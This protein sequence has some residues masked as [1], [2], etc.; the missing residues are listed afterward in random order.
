MK[1]VAR[2][3]AWLL[4]LSIP[5]SLPQ[6]Q[7]G[8]WVGLCAPVAEAPSV[9]KTTVSSS[10]Y[11]NPNRVVIGWMVIGAHPEEK[12]T[13]AFTAVQVMVAGEKPLAN[14]VIDTVPYVVPENAEGQTV[15]GNFSLSRPN[16]GW[17]IG[18]YRLDLAMRGEAVASCSFSIH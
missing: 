2:A 11:A 13:G 16:N 17:P 5:S 4:F 10:E 3:I 12:I 14:Y 1:N 6:A 8:Q 9:G 15:W 7:A 18:D